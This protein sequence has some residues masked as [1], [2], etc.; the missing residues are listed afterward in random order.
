MKSTKPSSLFCKPEN[1]SRIN[2][3]FNS[4]LKISVSVGV[5]GAVGVVFAVK[6]RRYL[7]FSILDQ[8]ADSP[9]VWVVPGLQ[10][11]G[12]N[13]FLNVVLQALASCLSFR[14]YL[15]EVMEEYGSL[16]AEEVDK[17]WGDE[18]PPLASSLTSLVEE[19]CTVRHQR[20][21]LNP[22]ELMAA[23][24]HYIPN[25]NLARQQDAEEAFSHL[26]SSLR[27][28]ISEHY[29]PNKSSLADLPALPNGRILTMKSCEEENDWQRWSRSFLKPFDGIIGS[30][31]VC[32][33]CTFQ[34]E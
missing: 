32:Q 18:N 10:N 12:N 20:T 21:V 14:K 5:L 19:L 15:L 7:N 31:L 11:L 33:S 23:M 1:G 29:V 8:D 34:V 28:E 25:F 16:S 30:I 26:L 4:G 6:F 2:W 22:R 3:V 24:D 27:E 9:R 17:M 13:C